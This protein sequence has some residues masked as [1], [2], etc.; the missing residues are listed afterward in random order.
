MLLLMVFAVSVSVVDALLVMQIRFGLDLCEN[1]DKR[2]SNA[3]A[4]ARARATS[5]R[6]IVMHF[7][8]YC[9][10]F[11]ISETSNCKP[12]NHEFARGRRRRQATSEISTALNII[13][14]RSRTK[15]RSYANPTSTRGR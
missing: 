7:E 15:M 13:H 6:V 3:V 4:A 5:G 10:N 11:T 9:V 12:L 14:F 8:F 1:I 2:K